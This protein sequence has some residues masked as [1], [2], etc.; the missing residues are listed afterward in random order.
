MSSFPLSKEQADACLAHEAMCLIS[1]NYI[2]LVGEK[3][4]T[5]ICNIDSSDNSR[6]V[7]VGYRSV[8]GMI[9]DGKGAFVLGSKVQLGYVDSPIKDVPPKILM[10]LEDKTKVIVMDF[11]QAPKTPTGTFEYNW[12]SAKLTWTGWR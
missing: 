1:N 3:S 10:L 7:E 5:T 8:R 2:D 12:L 11:S 4:H 9:S 6:P